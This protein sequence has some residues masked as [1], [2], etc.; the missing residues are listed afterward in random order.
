MITDA[1]LVTVYAYQDDLEGNNL[2]ITE[3]VHINDLTTWQNQN[4]GILSKH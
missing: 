1:S 3:M 4:Y 2:Q